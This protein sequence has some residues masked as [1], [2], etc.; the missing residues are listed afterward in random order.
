MTT[1]A[2]KHRSTID[3][4]I[5]LL[6][7][8]CGKTRGLGPADVTPRIISSVERYLPGDA[9]KADVRAFIDEVKCD[10][11]CL[12]LACERGDDAAW[13]ELVK[14]FDQTVRSAARKITANAEDADDLASSIWAELY[15][16]RHD[17]QGN[18][19]SKLTYYSGRGSLGGWLRAVVAQLAVDQH[20]KVSR[21]VQIEEER[22]MDALASDSCRDDVH[23]SLTSNGSNPE[24]LLTGK[25][26]SADVRDALSV[27]IA[28]LDPEDRL[29]LKLY[30]FE[31]LKLKEIAA[32]FGYHEA[33]ASRKLARLQ[34]DIRKS[35]EKGLRERHGWTETEVK[36]H[37]SG[38][39]ADLELSVETMLA[40]LMA[41]A[42]LQDWWT[43]TF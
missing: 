15:G 25:L 38:V 36:Q 6:M 9:P 4:A 35:V 18:K 11:L 26:S 27:A 34:S 20:R 16:L 1:V 17:P 43:V 39:A 8:K 37:L 31:E 42:L 21:F 24:E 5:S 29:I 12:V 40:V 14:D 28:G 30:Y 22:Q 19:K 33:T 7:A 41:A 32:T 2:Q 13:N 10:D 3:D 23:A